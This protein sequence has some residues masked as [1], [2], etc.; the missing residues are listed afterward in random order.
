[1]ASLAFALA[2]ALPAFSLEKSVTPAMDAHVL[3]CV[4]AVYEMD[5]D[6]ADKEAALLTA[7]NP[8]HPFG[9]FGQT[10]VLWMRYT[11]GSDQTDQTLLQPF[12]DSVEK[13]V[14]VGKAWMKKHPE[15]AQA[16][17]ALGAAHG[18]RARLLVSKRQWVKGY[19]NART[20][21]NSVKKAQKLDPDLVDAKLGTAMYDY[22]TD[23]Y[24]H[25]V[26]ALAKIVLRGSRK[27]GIEALKVLAEKGHYTPTTAKMLLVEIYTKDPFGAKDPEAAIALMKE[28]RKEY[29]KSAMLHA[30]ELSSLS[31]ASRH[32]EVLKGAQEYLQRTK[33]GTYSPFDAAKGHLFI[34]ESLRALGK[35]EEAAGAFQKASAV[36]FGPTLST[37]R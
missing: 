28:I 32:E 19:L 3:K 10:L 23:L 14:A 4:D 34:A 20:A 21:M 16:L 25:F 24:P 15:D 9:Y 37:L 6:R 5:F 12:E 31:Q 7:A 17:L 22:Y 2:L 13:T 26:G 18:T 33:N 8:E 1:M 11:Y 29:P 35:L 27:R 30:A 36:A